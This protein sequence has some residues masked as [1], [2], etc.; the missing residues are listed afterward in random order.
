MFEPVLHLIRNAADHGIEAAADHGY[1]AGKP[2]RG[3]IRLG[4]S[5]ILDQVVIEVADDGKGIDPAK[6]RQTIRDRALLG[7]DALA[8]LSDTQATDMIFTPGFSTAAT[9]TE[10]SGRGVGTW[11]RSGRR[12]PGWA[13]GLRSPH[14]RASAPGSACPCR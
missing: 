1:G 8:A 3:S 7:D 12:S 14:N 13:D 10:L 4:A 6:I 11:I 2:A 5:R 9:V